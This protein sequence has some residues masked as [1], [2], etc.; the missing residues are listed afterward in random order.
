MRLDE[1]KIAE[2]VLDDE[3]VLLNL[4]TSRYMF[5]NAV[6]VGLLTQLRAGLDQD[7]MVASIV[8]RYALD[9]G[10]AKADVAA[11]VQQLRDEALLIE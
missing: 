6:G 2:T 8:N 5:V 7:A 9:C 10:T 11:F 1:S 3:V 4:E